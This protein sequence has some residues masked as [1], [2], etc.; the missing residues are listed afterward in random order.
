MD[1]TDQSLVAALRANARASISELAAKLG[2]ARATVRARI[3]R[4]LADEE[5]LGFTIILKGDTTP[6]PIRGI[7]LIEIEGKGTDRIIRQLNGMPEVQLIHATNGRWD[8]IVELGTQTLAD[9]DAVLRRI[10]LIDGI[11][12]SETNLLMATKSRAGS[13]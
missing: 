10:R 13:S 5:I 7:T 4:L 6:L 12:G 3:D 9:L 8:L 1:K 2:L 11:A